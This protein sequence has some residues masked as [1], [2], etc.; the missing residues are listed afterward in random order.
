M[1][2]NRPVIE[3]YHHVVHH[4]R[5]HDVHRPILRRHQHKTL[6]QSLEHR[7]FLPI[8]AVLRPTNQTSQHPA[9]A[10]HVTGHFGLDSPRGS[11]KFHLKT[12]QKR[13]ER[14]DGQENREKAGL[15]LAPSEGFHDGF[16]GGEH[17]GVELSAE[18]GGER[19]IREELGALGPG[20]AVA[21]HKP[22]QSGGEKAPET[23]GETRSGGLPAEEEEG[24]AGD[25][26][27]EKRERLVGEK[28]PD[29]AM[30]Q[31]EEQLGDRI[32]L[33]QSDPL[34][35][36]RATRTS[37]RLR[38]R[39]RVR[40]LRITVLPERA[41]AKYCFDRQRSKCDCSDSCE[42]MRNEFVVMAALPDSP[43]SVSPVS[44]VSPVSS[45]CRWR[46]ASASVQLS[47]TCRNCP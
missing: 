26:G 5:S 6:Q 28:E 18:H 45:A 35:A 17:G 47:S 44:P 20:K 21:K 27:G 12:R 39:A 30:L 23:R 33:L 32:D 42:L 25:G 40:P 34:H 10:N 22:A 8:F 4:D 24:E 16:H 31:S 46:A 1:S 7:Q 2:S 29:A 15:F 13:S 43:S 14:G 19:E 38:R 11:L 3:L 9:T 36:L 41:T 37:R